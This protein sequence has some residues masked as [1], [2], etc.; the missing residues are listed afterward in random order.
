MKNIEAILKE[1]GLEVTAEQLAAIEK[2]VKENY[3]TVVD[4]DKQKEKLDAAGDK[5][6]TLEESLEKFKDVDPEALKQ[7]IEDLKK[8]LKQKDTEY[9]GKIAD[10]DFEDVLKDAISGAKG[11][12]A[13]AIRAL[14]D[15]D[16]LKASKNQKDDVAAAIK[17]LTE[18]EDSA[19]LFA[20]DDGDEPDGDEPDD[21]DDDAAG[22]VGKAD[23]IGTVKGGSGDSFLAG[24]RSS[25][26][27]ASSATEKKE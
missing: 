18:A 25:M 11:K 1:A 12:N 2:A 19:F 10:R 15:L 20:K 6:K 16:T 27:L 17:A 9:A 4:Y 14:L 7:S 24:L 26:G 3:K 21:A 13:K 23:V 5:A 22:V 8:E